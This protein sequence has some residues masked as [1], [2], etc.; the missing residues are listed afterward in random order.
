MQAY[1]DLMQNILDNGVNRMDRTGV[2]T[3]SIFGGELHFD[4]STFPLITT[5]K[6]HL[7]SIV[8]EL[9]WFLNGSTNVQPLNEM[10]VTI[11]DEWANEDGELGPVYGKQWRSWTTPDGRTID[12][13]SNVINDL[14]TNPFSRRHIV[15]AWNV[16]EIDK[17][18][19]PPCHVMFQFYVDNDNGLSCKLTQR[20]CDVFLG[21]PFNIA[22]YGLLT[23]MI[24]QQCNLTPR[25]FIW[26]GGDIHLYNNHIKQAEEQLSRTPYSLP[27]LVISDKPKDIFSYTA[28]HFTIKDYTYHPRI[29]APIA[30]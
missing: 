25:K 13:I 16:G 21:V 19:L 6:M 22:S 3:R 10:G 26:S 30:V 24:A 14:K 23:C 4:L 27:T 29:P 1:L 5:K 28:K 11:W 18:A 2:G 7:K 17:M 20:S 9:L 15:S 8:H 12:Q